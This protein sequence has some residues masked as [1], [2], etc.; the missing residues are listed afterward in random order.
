[1]SSTSS[2]TPTES[3][4]HVD[5]YGAGDPLV[6]V[7]GAWVSGAMWR[8]QVNHFMDRYRV[9]TVDIRGHGKTGPT[10]RSE[11][12]VPLFA[13]D[14]H[15]ALV[16]IDAESPVICGLSLG[17]LIAQAYAIRY[18][19]T[20]RG[21]ILAD[22]VWSIPPIPITGLQKRLFFPKLPLYSTIRMIGPERWYRLLLS[23]VEAI[24]GHQWLAQGASAREYALSEVN[25]IPHREFIKI[26]DALYSFDPLSVSDIEIPTALV[27]GDHETPAILAQNRTLQNNIY[28][29]TKHVIPNAGHLSNLDNPVEFNAAVKT[30]LKRVET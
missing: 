3:G 29:A 15:D 14:L 23:S 8:P 9:I 26:Y 19:T 25:Q 24:T 10:S 1:M 28:N 20:P 2:V 16:E 30:L 4:I 12:T 13:D 6:F 11:Y 22:T 27:V 21:L 7:H 5:E 18:P 17:G